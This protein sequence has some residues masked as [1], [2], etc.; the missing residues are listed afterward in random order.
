[1]V[2]AIAIHN[3]RGPEIIARIYSDIF[4]IVKPGGAFLNLE[5]VRPGD[6]A[7]AANAKAGLVMEQWR[8]FEETGVQPSLEDLATEQAGQRASW[9]GGRSGHEDAPYALGQPQLAPRRRIRR[10]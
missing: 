7:R 2:S 3:L 10:G 6:A 8:R 9:S 4:T 5:L 1:M